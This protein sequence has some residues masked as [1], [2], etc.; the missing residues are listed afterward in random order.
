MCEVVESSQLYIA[1]RPHLVAQHIG[2]TAIKTKN[3]IDEARQAT[4]L[5]DEAYQ[6]APE[7]GSRDFGKEA[8]E[9]IMDTIEGDDTTTTDRPA[10]IFAGYPKEMQNFLELNP[11]LLRRMTHILHFPDYSTAELAQICKIVAKKNGFVVNVRSSTMV[12]HLDRL[13]KSLCSQMNAGL[14]QNIIGRAKTIL[15][16]K[17]VFVM[18]RQPEKITPEFVTTID[19]TIFEQAVSDI[20]SKYITPSC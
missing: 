12:K 11:G 5:V 17:L 3:K 6:L 2:E 8:V 16:E 1:T 14:S 18:L 20:R 7:E 19:E 9:T 4:L 15:K 13:P 10:Y